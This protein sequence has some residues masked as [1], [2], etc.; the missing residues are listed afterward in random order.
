[1]TLVMIYLGFLIIAIIDLF[2]LIR[3]KKIKGIIIFSI[4]L[5]AGLTFSTLLALNVEVPSLLLKMGEFLKMVGL[6]YK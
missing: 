5:V 1:M 2:P 4:F 6:A 3:M